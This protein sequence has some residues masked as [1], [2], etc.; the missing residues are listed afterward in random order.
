M[1][2]LL[3]TFLFVV[4]VACAAPR[5]PPAPAPSP[6]PSPAPVSSAPVT[7]APVVAAPAILEA[8]RNWQLLDEGVDHVPGISAE[9]A[10]RE[11]LAGKQP[12]R[13]VTVAI[14]DSGIDTAHVEL[15]SSLWTNARE[16]PGNGRDDDNNGYADDVRGW[17]FI[18]G[19]DGRD[20]D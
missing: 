5:T 8:P 6:S 12:T 18:G 7:P 4:A 16:V 14:I 3:S 11:L 1:K 19:R 10:Q 13:T 15:R 17:N 9:R 2:K 20:V